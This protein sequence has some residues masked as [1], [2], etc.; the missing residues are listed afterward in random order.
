MKKQL[1]IN[2]LA[3]ITVNG[4][5]GTVLN[6]KVFNKIDLAKRRIKEGSASLPRLIVDTCRSRR[7]FTIGGDLVELRKSG[8]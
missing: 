2:E 3:I 1:Y 5:V 4:L 6:Y 7:G 8:N